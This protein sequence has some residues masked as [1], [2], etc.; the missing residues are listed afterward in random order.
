M[1]QDVG[2]LDISVDDT[3]AMGV[4]VRLG[5]VRRILHRLTHRELMLPIQPVT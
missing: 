1:H 4:V 5:Q 3:V 2:G